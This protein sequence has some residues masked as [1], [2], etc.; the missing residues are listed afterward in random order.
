VPLPADFQFSQS[1]LQDYVDCARRF[2][3]R[4]VQRL[5]WPAV[6]A[7]P[8][9]EYE[10]HMRQGEK[11]HR[12]VHQHTLGIAPEKLTALIQE[13]ALAQWWN[14]YLQYGLHDLPGQRYAEIMLSVPIAKYRLIA[15]YDL[16]AVTPGQQAV[17]VDWKTALHRPSRDRLSRLL[18]TVVYRYVL[19]QAGRQM[20]GG[21]PLLPQQIVMM[22][23]FANYPHQP[24]VFQYDDSQFEEDQRLLNSLIQDISERRDDLWE[25]TSKMERCQFCGYRSLC[26]RGEKAGDFTIIDFDN[27]QDNLDLDFDFE[28]IAEIEF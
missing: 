20:N 17:I 19:A 25:L 23:W 22:Y 4:H 13:D 21:Q 2:Q 8:V 1:N 3:L 16:I 15:K 14:N 28:Q 12:L 27:E 9:L 5:V 10:Q 24:E 18:Q 26:N 6:E 7:E 11:F